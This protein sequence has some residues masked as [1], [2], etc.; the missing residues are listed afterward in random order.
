MAQRLIQLAIQATL[1]ELQETVQDCA[2]G[3][4]WTAPANG[5]VLQA[6]LLVEVGASEQV[7]DVL[8][9]RF[10]ER[11]QFSV[12]LL[13][14][15]ASL[16][17]PEELAGDD[18]SSDKTESAK[19]DNNAQLTDKSA[20]NLEDHS[21]SQSRDA[22]IVKQLHSGKDDV[23]TSQV[24]DLGDNDFNDNDFNDNDLDDNNLDDN[25]LKD[26]DPDKSDPD[27]SDPDKNDPNNGEQ[28]E[29]NNVRPN[30]VSREELY[31]DI[32]DSIGVSWQYLT[33]V[34]LS[35][36]VAAAGM[37]RDNVAI[38]IGAMVIAPL[39][40]PNIALSLATTLADF[41]LARRTIGINL[42]GLTIAFA[43]AV[44]FGMLFP[45]SLGSSEL[46]SRTQ[47]SL[48]DIGIALASGVAGAL[49]FTTGASTATIGVMVAVAL[50][51]PWVAVGVLVGDGY[52]H[53]ALGALSLFGCNIICVNLA[54]VG[55]FLV[56]GLRP[57]DSR[58]AKQ[59]K[60]ATFIAIAVWVLLLVALA[61]IIRFSD[62]V[63][64]SLP[65]LN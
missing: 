19:A 13:E 11:D 40:G 58:E 7:L 8:E 53:L 2:L 6:S 34:M 47:V 30:R 57:A 31:N 63:E 25:N 44:G 22:E 55:T 61:S 45:V 20:D 41:K 65:E 64:P 27:K 36:V 59:A 26:D 50:L 23:A 35:T 14:V 3:A 17:R 48:A 21:T 29:D 5:D 49:A 43:L 33:M 10:A 9:Q 15:Q 32:N 60:L 54:G 39:L 52:N 42:L 16:P 12:V 18:D 24:D 56:Q 28:D 46:A 51:P 38:I 37:I 4:F 62:L 1:E